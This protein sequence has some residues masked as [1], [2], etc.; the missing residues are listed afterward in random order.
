MQH[1]DLSKFCQGVAL[2]E[3]SS[4]HMCGWNKSK[5]TASFTS[6]INVAPLYS[7]GIYYIFGKT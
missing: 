3:E 5:Y 6:I 1:K 7:D 4:Q 2:L